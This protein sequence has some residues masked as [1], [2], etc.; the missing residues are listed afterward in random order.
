MIK[1]T[2]LKQQ[3]R[4]KKLTGS[5]TVHALSI[6]GHHGVSSITHDDRTAAHMVWV[7]LHKNTT[8]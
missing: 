8:V 1:L 4:V 2:G 7:A 3:N 6:E 5:Y